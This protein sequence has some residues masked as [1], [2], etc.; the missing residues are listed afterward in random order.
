MCSLSPLALPPLNPAHEQ[1][2]KYKHP[3]CSNHGQHYVFNTDTTASIG[4][5]HWH[6]ILVVSM[7]AAHAQNSF[8]QVRMVVTHGTFGLL[9]VAAFMESSN[10]PTAD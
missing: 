2:T 4:S 10:M 5:Q 8:C 1:Y 6:L 3:N 7:Y 9:V